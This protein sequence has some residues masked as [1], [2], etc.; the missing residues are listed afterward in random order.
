DGVSDT[1][2]F[3]VCNVDD[4][5]TIN[6]FQDLFMP[7]LANVKVYQVVEVNNVTTPYCNNC[8]ASLASFTNLTN[9]VSLVDN[10][11]SGTLTLKFLAFTDE[12]D[13]D[14]I[15]PTECFSDTV[16]YIISL[17]PPVTAADIVA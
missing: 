9:T 17:Y 16:I 4:N 13:D 11:M 5:I 15:D 6:E 7:P 14:I 3:D 2:S 12:N 10:T 1:L 8:V